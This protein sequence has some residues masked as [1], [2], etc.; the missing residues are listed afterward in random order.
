[1]FER[2][3]DARKRGRVYFEE[4]DYGRYY[5]VIVI[6]FSKDLS[7][8]ILHEIYSKLSRDSAWELYNEWS[9]IIKCLE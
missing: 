3:A 2:Y 5:E 4:K 8:T 6:V 7:K 1:M 9:E